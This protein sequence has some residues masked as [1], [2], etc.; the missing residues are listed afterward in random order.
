[1]TVRYVRGVVCVCV[2]F[3]AACC[4]PLACFDVGCREEDRFVA[5]GGVGGEG[6]AALLS[7]SRSHPG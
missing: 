1:M 4:L 6:G 2:C 3:L 7:L 5:M